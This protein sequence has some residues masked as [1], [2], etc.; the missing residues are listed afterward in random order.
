MKPF[1]ARLTGSR[2]ELIVFRSSRH[3]CRS[4]AWTC[5]CVVVSTDAFTGRNSLV[6][7]AHVSLRV[8]RPVRLPARFQWRSCDGISG[9]SVNRRLQP[10]RAPWH[11]WWQRKIWSIKQSHQKKKCTNNVDCYNDTVLTHVQ[12]ISYVRNNVSALKALRYYFRKLPLPSKPLAQTHKLLV[13]SAGKSWPVASSATVTLGNIP[14]KF[15][16]QKDRQT[17]LMR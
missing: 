13:H 8:A 4:V 1:D 12:Y 9:R 6:L 5:G 3:I 7:T 17:S 15:W 2:W 16:S 10:Q 11:K 14:S